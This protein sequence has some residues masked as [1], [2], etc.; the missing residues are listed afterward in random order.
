MRHLSKAF[1]AFLLLVCV[2]TTQAQDSDNPWLVG[3]GYN[4]VDFNSAGATGNGRFDGFFKF[5]NYNFNATAF[6]FS[7][8]R[9]LG[10]GFSV[11]AALSLNTI[12]RFGETKLDKDL[13]YLAFDAGAKYD[14]NNLVGQTGWFDPY[15]GLGLGYVSVE[16]DATSSING[17]AGF[18]IWFAEKFGLYVQTMYKRSMKAEDVA[19]HFQHSAGLVYRFGAKDTDNDGIVDKKDKCPEVFGL[20]EFDGCPDT[21]GDGVKDSEDACPEIA[22][23]KELGGCPD[24]DKDGIADQND[25]CPNAKGTVKNGGC[26]DTDGDGVVDKD[27]ACPN[28]KGEKGNNGCPWVDTDGDGVLDKDDAYP[29]DPTMWT[30]EQFLR[31]ERLKNAIAKIQ[32]NAKA[33]KF[34]V[35]SARFTPRKS[36]QLDEIVALMKENKDANF[37]IQGNTDN[38]GSEEINQK[39]SV[40][41]AEGVKKYLVKA[42]IEASRIEVKGLGESNPIDSNDTWKGR[43]KNRRVD[44]VIINL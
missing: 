31:K 43:A 42:G 6:R 20:E 26:P 30:K 16:D 35:G 36:K 29:N 37:L 4:A 9:Y 44:F 5:D 21:D 15:L 12:D 24:A 25:A 28:K 8:A 11:E 41:R 19:R 3:V 27:D 18:N 33:I 40:R 38:T 39:L 22:G 2:G 13:S 7:G 10:S 32:E 34:G 23:E 17:T 1:L 14:I